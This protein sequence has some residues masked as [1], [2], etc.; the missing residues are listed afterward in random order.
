MIRSR[1][2][3]VVTRKPAVAAPN[4]QWGTAPLWLPAPAP[5]QPGRSRRQRHPSG[6]DACALLRLRVVG[7]AGEQPAQLDSS[8]QFTSLIEGGADRVGFCLGDDEH[9]GRMGA[10][11]MVG[12]PDVC[13][14]TPLSRNGRRRVLAMSAIIASSNVVCGPTGPDRDE[15]AAEFR[16]TNK[17]AGAPPGS[18]M[19][20]RK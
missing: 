1:P 3:L 11:T 10:R 7:D 4:A 17:L 14:H 19:R 2:A 8:R 6:N 9:G 18:V 16:R 20:P 12:K 15:L 5:R 13:G